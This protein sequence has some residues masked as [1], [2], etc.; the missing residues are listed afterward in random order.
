MVTHSRAPVR[1]D[2]LRALNV[3]VR[4][5]VRLD[6]RGLPVEVGEVESGRSGSSPPPLIT[7]AG[8]A[9]GTASTTPASPAPPAGGLAGGVAAPATQSR[10][11]EEVLEIWR[12]DDEWWRRPISRRYVEVV[13][14]GGAHVVLFEDLVTGDWFCQMP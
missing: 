8:E 9:G 13:L 7:P 10:C 1:V 3:P 5:L 11:V 14:E 6:E 4:V 2:R 12:I